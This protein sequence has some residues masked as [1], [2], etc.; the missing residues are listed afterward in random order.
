MKNII[1]SFLLSINIFLAK[2]QENCFQ[3]TVKNISNFLKKDCNWNA[4][5]ILLNKIS[6]CPD[7]PLDFKTKAANLQAAI[8]ECKKN[9]Q[10]ISIT[11][12]PAHHYLIRKKNEKLGT[13][14]YFDNT[15]KKIVDYIYDDAE[16]FENGF[17]NVKKGDNWGIINHNGQ[18]IEKLNW[19]KIF[20][21]QGMDIKDEW[22]TSVLKNN[23]L[24]KTPEDDYSFIFNKIILTTKQGK[25]TVYDCDKREFLINDKYTSINFVFDTDDW[26]ELAKFKKNPSYKYSISNAL[27]LRLEKD[28]VLSVINLN[29]KKIVDEGIYEEIEESDEGLIKISRKGKEGFINLMGREVIKPVFNLVSLPYGGLIPVKDTNDLYGFID[30]NGKI[31]FKCEY[32]SF[33]YPIGYNTYFENGVC[34]VF[35]KNNEWAYLRRDGSGIISD[36]FTD[37]KGFIGKYAAVQKNNKH[38]YLIENIG[39][40]IKYIKLDY[41]F[42]N[43]EAER[44]SFT[45]EHKFI[46]TTFQN[47][48]KVTLSVN[49][50]GKLVYL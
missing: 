29:G 44:N 2:A 18:E 47:N 42:T 6:D 46:F 30:Y 35:T 50:E 38:W 12:T 49:K 5:Q 32:I 43:C 23:S 3:T 22:G 1:L 34:P 36:Q 4:A 26:I 24:F 37:V 40:V 45:G 9:N 31:E 10:K 21:E 7:K 13:Y 19:Y 33:K 11:T 27:L 8:N 20:F 17:A 25:Q 39:K 41:D 14:G 28:S 48:K 15:G 16:D